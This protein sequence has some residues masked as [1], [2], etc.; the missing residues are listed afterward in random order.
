MDLGFVKGDE[1]LLVRALRALLETA[2]KFSQEG[3][4]IRLTYEAI[5]GFLRVILEGHGRTIPESVLPKFFDV[6]SAAEASTPAKD[7]GMAP[8][9]AHRILSLFGASVSVANLG[10]SGIRLTIP[11]RDTTQIRACPSG[12]T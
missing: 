6:F 1:D 12:E 7:L 3:E 4:T 8:A 2:V 5:P 10:S 11:L 9:V